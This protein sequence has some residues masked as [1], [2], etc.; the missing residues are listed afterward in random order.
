MR[1][2]TLKG[3]RAARSRSKSDGFGDVVIIIGKNR[4][5]QH[6]RSFEGPIAFLGV[7]ELYLILYMRYPELI[8]IYRQY[9][10][11]FEH[12]MRVLPLEQSAFNYGF[13]LFV[14]IIFPKHNGIPII[15]QRIDILPF[16]N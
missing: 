13:H 4:E 1:N 7:F 16:E 15:K 8:F 3:Q 14:S 2:G 12:V 9:S 5:S 6:T 11:G 10:S